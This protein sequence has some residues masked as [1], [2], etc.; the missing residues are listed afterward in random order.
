MTVLGTGRPLELSLDLFRVL[1][2]FAEQTTTRQAFQ[3]LDVNIDI[4]AFSRI[5]TDFVACGLLRQ[6]Q[7]IDEGHDLRPLL[8]PEIFTNLALL[9][10]IGSCL[11]QGR[12]VVIPDALP[13]DLAER[14]HGELDRSTSWRLVEGGHDFFH[15]RNCVI[16]AFDDETPALM[17][18]S[19][20]FKSTATRRFIGELTG[21]DCTGDAGVAAA[22]YRSGEYA[23]PHDD[24]ASTAPRSV[25][26][27][28]YLAKGWRQEWGGALFWCPSGQYVRPRFNVLIMFQAVPSN[29][30]L[31]CPVAPSATEKRLTMNG[32]WHSAERRSLPPPLSP[33]AVVSPRAYGQPGPDD[34]E[35]APMIVL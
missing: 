2:M 27:I 26:Y 15:Y 9:D 16:E 24:S 21:E 32:F 17:Q 30:H 14:V 5:I 31:V 20:L 23:L 18:C 33:E 19:R 29:V 22:W 4:D 7:S 10:K 1:M 13:A 12:A 35:L 34:A 28:W 3:A 11:R 25:A 8:N 6:E